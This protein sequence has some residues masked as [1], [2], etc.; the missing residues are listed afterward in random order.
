MSDREFITHSGEE[1]IARGRELASRIKPPLLVLLAG[2]LGAGK[3]TLA[4]GIISGLG[5]ARVE[6]ITSPTFTLVHCFAGPMKVFH[7][8]L[9]RVA[10]AHDFHTL[11][12]EDLFDEPAI[13]LVE[14][15]D[16]MRLRTD[17]PVLRIQL[18]HAG[19]DKRK[20]SIEEITRH[21]AVQTSGEPA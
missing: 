4:K 13:V 1:T 9:Y 19:E 2:E 3:T 14:W 17:W 10:D 20:I 11:G 5:A 16:R 6:D 12:L 18:E 15:P 8:D 21:S 7:V